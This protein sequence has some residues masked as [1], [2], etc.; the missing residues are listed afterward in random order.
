MTGLRLYLVRHGEPVNSDMF[1]GHA[2]VG[3][4][5]R[6]LRQAEAVAQALADVPLRAIYSSDL[7][8]ATIGAARIAA[9]RPEHPA[10]LALPALREM[11][12]GVLERVAFRDGRARVPELASVGYDDL[13]DH[14][15]P[16]GESVR[17]LAGRVVPC[18]TALVAR[19]LRA[20]DE[21]RRSPPPAI[22]VVAHNTVNRVVLACAAGLG[23]AGYSRFEQAHGSLSRVDFPDT[24]SSA[25]PWAATR[26]GLV[27]WL[28]EAIEASGRSR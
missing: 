6:G 7:E 14:R 27:N 15:F 9:A 25:D 8:R 10:P 11:N 26:I 5:A 24:W 28:P 19:H 4:S 16:G 12:L 17:D 21:P 13:L 2:D 20:P 18:I 22:A 3:L 1:I 23:P